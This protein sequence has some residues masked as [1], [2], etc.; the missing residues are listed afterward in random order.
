MYHQHKVTTQCSCSQRVQVSTVPQLPTQPK[1]EPTP[2]KVVEQKVVQIQKKTLE[3]EIKGG[4]TKCLP[5]HSF[6]DTFKVTY[7][8]SNEFR[9][10]TDGTFHL[11]LVD[12]DETGHISGDLIGPYP[13]KS[14]G[15]YLEKGTAHSQTYKT[16]HFENSPLF[17]GGAGALVIRKTTSAWYEMIADGWKP[18][19]ISIYFERNG[20][21]FEKKF[22]FPKGEKEGWLSKNGFY[23]ITAKGK[24]KYVEGSE[25]AEA[26]HIVG[27]SV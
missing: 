12:V 6:E 19:M 24:F 4:E 5:R 15:S 18:E 2:Q 7:Q 14:E 26:R 20:E 22:F 17:R 11:Y 27:A 9:A 13:I 1:P 10:G 23:V 8:T 16:G 21:K 3:T 25:K